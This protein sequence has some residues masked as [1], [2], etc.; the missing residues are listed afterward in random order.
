MG[1]VLAE[2]AYS[3]FLQQWTWDSFAGSVDAAIQECLTRCS[4]MRTEPGVIAATSFSKGID[5]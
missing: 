1:E 2:R 3:R 4:Q 5:P